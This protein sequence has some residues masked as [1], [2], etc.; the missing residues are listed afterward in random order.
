MMRIF[1]ISSFEKERFDEMSDKQLLAEKYN[2][3]LK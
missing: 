3:V 2:V 1:S